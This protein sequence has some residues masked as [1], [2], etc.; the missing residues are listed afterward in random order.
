MAFAQPDAQPFTLDD[1]PEPHPL[2]APL[3]LQYH[4][5]IHRQQVGGVAAINQAT[6]CRCLLQK[7]NFRLQILGAACIDA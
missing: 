5:S 6:I 7:S 2:E 3:C 4:S 1:I